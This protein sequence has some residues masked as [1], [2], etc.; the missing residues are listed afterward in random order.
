MLFGLL[1]ASGLVK[2]VGLD[3]TQPPANLLLVPADSAQSAVAPVLQGVLRGAQGSQ[4]MIGGALLR[5]GDE[6]AG[7]RVLA[8]HPQSVLIERQGQRQLLRLVEPVM[9]PSR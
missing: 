8:I 5:V 6:H 1:L 7:A 2:A 4:A 3:P 9:Q